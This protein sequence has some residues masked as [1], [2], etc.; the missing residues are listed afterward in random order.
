MAIMAKES[1]Y[2]QMKIIIMI[3]IF[4]K[5]IKVYRSRFLFLLS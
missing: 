3:I 5:E 2:F 4:F 1:I